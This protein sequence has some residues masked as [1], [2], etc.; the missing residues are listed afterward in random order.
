MVASWNLAT[1][2]TEESVQNWNTSPG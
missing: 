2:E 1:S